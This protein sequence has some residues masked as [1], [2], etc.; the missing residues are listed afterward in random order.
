MRPQCMNLRVERGNWKPAGWTLKQN[1]GSLSQAA[2]LLWNIA[3]YIAYS[4]SSSDVYFLEQFDPNIASLWN[5]GQ[6]DSKWNVYTWFNDCADSADWTVP[7]V[8]VDESTNILNYSNLTDPFVRSKPDWVPDFLNKKTAFTRVNNGTISNIVDYLWPDQIQQYITADQVKVG[9]SGI[10]AFFK[11][12]VQLDPGQVQYILGNFG[13]KSL[14]SIMNTY[15]DYDV[16]S[17]N[18]TGAYISLAKI[19]DYPIQD[20]LTPV[21]AGLSLQQ[22]GQIMTGFVTYTNTALGQDDA[23]LG[24]GYSAES[25]GKWILADFDVA[26]PL[27]L[28][29]IHNV[30]EKPDSWIR[31]SDGKQFDH[32]SQNSGGKTVAPFAKFLSAT[33]IFGKTNASLVEWGEWAYKKGY[34][35]L[36]YPLE[37]TT[38]KPLSRA[39]QVRVAK[40]SDLNLPYNTYNVNLGLGST[41]TERDF[42]KQLTKATDWTCIKDV[43]YNDPGIKGQN[44][45]GLFG[46]ADYVTN[47]YPTELDTI[48]VRVNSQGVV[49]CMAQQNE[50]GELECIKGLCQYGTPCWKF[51]CRKCKKDP[52]LTMVSDE[53]VLTMSE[54][55]LPTELMGYGKCTPNIV[56]DSSA[57]IP[58]GLDPSWFSQAPLSSSQSLQCDPSNPTNWCK[59]ASE[60]LKPFV[61]RAKDGRGQGLFI[62]QKDLSWIQDADVANRHRFYRSNDHKPAGIIGKDVRYICIDSTTDLNGSTKVFGRECGDDDGRSCG[63][64]GFC[65]DI[66]GSGYGRISGTRDGNLFFDAQ[67]YQSKVKG[68]N[69][70]VDYS[71]E[72]LGNLARTPFGVGLT[73]TYDMQKSKLEDAI[74]VKEDEISKASKIVQASKDEAL[75][76]QQSKVISSAKSE[77]AALK[78]QLQNVLMNDNSTRWLLDDKGRFHNLSD[79]EQCMTLI[80]NVDRWSFSRVWNKDYTPNQQGVFGIFS[81]YIDPQS[82]FQTASTD[83]SGGGQISLEACSDD[84]QL[85]K[86]LREPVSSTPDGKV[87]QCDIE[88]GSLQKWSIGSFNNNQPNTLTN[89]ALVDYWQARKYADQIADENDLMKCDAI[90]DW[91]LKFFENPV[92]W[93]RKCP[94]KAADQLKKGLQYKLLTKNDYTISKIYLNGFGLG[95]DLPECG[96]G[97]DLPEALPKALPVKIEGGMSHLEFGIG[98]GGSRIKDRLVVIIHIDTGLIVSPRTVRVQ[99]QYKY[100]LVNGFALSKPDSFAPDGTKLTIAQAIFEV[101]GGEWFEFK[102]AASGKKIGISTELGNMVAVSSDLDD[103]SVRWK[104]GE[105]TIT[106]KLFDLMLTPQTRDGVAF[107]GAALFGT[108]QQTKFAFLVLGKVGSLKLDKSVIQ[109]ASDVDC[110]YTSQDSIEWDPSCQKSE[111]GLWFKDFPPVILTQP[112][113]K[114][115]A[116]PQSVMTQCETPRDCQVAPP[117]GQY[118]WDVATCKL[119]SDGNF[120][121]TVPPLILLPPTPGGQPCPETVKV[122][123]QPPKTCLFSAKS[124]QPWD[125]TC[126]KDPV[127]GEWSKQMPPDVFYRPSAMSIAAGADACPSTVTTKCMKPSGGQASVDFCLVSTNI[128]KYGYKDLDDCL[129]K[130]AIGGIPQDCKVVFPELGTSPICARDDNGILQT[131]I[132][133]TP[134][135]SAKNG[136]LCGPAQLLK[137][138]PCKEP[139]VSPEL[140]GKCFN[141]WYDQKFPTVQAC[142]DS[143]TGILPMPTLFTPMPEDCKIQWPEIPQNSVGCSRAPDGSDNFFVYQQGTVVEPAKEGGSCKTARLAACPA[144][145]VPDNVV[146]LCSSESERQ[147]LGFRSYTECVDKY[148]ID[149]Q[150]APQDCKVQWPEVPRDSVGCSRAADGSNNF[151]IFQRGAVIEPAK[152]GGQCAQTRV[153]EC[154]APV[155]SAEL[156][157]FCASEE[158]RQRNGFRTYTDCLDEYTIKGKPMPEDCKLQWPEVL[159]NSLGCVRDPVTNVLTLS[160]N[161]TI[162]EQAKNGGACKPT[163]TLTCSEPIISSEIVRLCSNA[164]ARTFYGFPNYMK[165]AD[166]FTIAG[167]ALPE[168]CKV[169]WPEIPANSV[170]CVRGADGGLSIVQNGTVVEPAKN[171]G[172]CNPTRVAVCPQPVIPDAVVRFCSSEENRIRNGF[173]SYGECADKYTIGGIPL[174]EDC[175][176]QWP[177]LPNNSVGCIRDPT[178]GILSIQQNATILEQAKNGGDCKPTRVAICSEPVVSAQIMTFCNNPENRTRNNYPSYSACVD[179][180]T[181]K[182]R[183]APK[184]CVVEWRTPPVNCTRD[185]I[186]LKLVGTQNATVLQPAENGGACTYTR[187]TTCAEPTVPADVD[188]YCGLNWSKLGY[189]S[190]LACTDDFVLNGKVL[191]KDCTVGF[192]STI[193]LK[194]CTRDSYTKRL[195][196]NQV[197]SII[198][199]AVGGGSCPSTMQ[200]RTIECPDPIALGT[201]P[202]NV[203]S[204][205]GKPEVVASFGNDTYRCIDEFTIYGR[206]VPQDCVLRWPDI[207]TS[208]QGC[209]RIAGFGAQGLRISQIASVVQPAVG[210]GYCPSIVR[211]ADC[212]EPVVSRELNQFCSSETRIFGKYNGSWQQC[213][214]AQL[215][216]PR[217]SP[218]AD[219]MSVLEGQVASTKEQFDAL[220]TFNFETLID[221]YDQSTDQWSTVVTP[222]A[223][224]TISAWVK[225]QTPATS[226]EVTGLIFG[227]YPTGNFGVAIYG[228]GQPRFFNNWAPDVYPSPVFK[229]T[230]NVWYHLVWTKNIANG[231]ITLF[232]NGVK[233][234]TW[235]GIINDA[236][237][238]YKNIRI[239]VDNHPGRAYFKGSLSTINVYSTVLSDTD[240]TRIY[241][242]QLPIVPK[243]EGFGYRVSAREG[244][245]GGKISNFSQKTMATAAVLL[246]VLFAARQILKLKN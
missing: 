192:P 181:I 94:L 74:R 102:H 208:Y 85:V 244:F 116:C 228:G 45:F 60:K 178:T 80:P 147:R 162:L 86:K 198:E 114:G 95:L 120:Y 4:T 199:P 217:E 155:V 2:D 230:P 226:T 215:G 117:Q 41:T 188:T 189:K 227:N 176:L 240:I 11:S 196:T 84:L 191:P 220:G 124:T 175:K 166:Y 154:P 112:R 3:N 219:I 48:A 169:Q 42:V 19:S 92:M 130:T 33:E 122:P 63:A 186:S 159:P 101:S 109:T 22:D 115:A 207:P 246:I 204:Y 24:V 44:F 238:N 182:G 72:N 218:Q 231:T 211:K 131:T 214:D 20:L 27:T 25:I 179:E 121:K 118:P 90:G 104:A 6:Y 177:G 141:A 28:N 127:T 5:S 194:T 64:G 183:P 59:T 164:E 93:T 31:C 38:N 241:N 132:V 133:G 23:T 123:C 54:D 46:N 128:S 173:R 221:Y 13:E 57:K 66:D 140:Y 206:Q 106:N 190:K 78:V 76:E 62:F 200:T 108:L 35:M 187:T 15:K 236:N 97:C 150:P 136:G 34:D 125:E 107:E 195:Y 55:N 36:N 129:E 52:A 225:I 212:P 29:S 224:G 99:D 142:L 103:D 18:P 88:D 156:I 197:A 39:A 51:G 139:D 152:N 113:G 100:K 65:E 10:T 70:V 168:D 134:Y 73:G 223:P 53:D 202:E 49:E 81:K 12:G 144:P 145:V 89:L 161:A 239:G 119:E 9:E 7:T 201:V 149:G 222:T 67:N 68:T 210:G 233:K 163:R 8:S 234:F 43:R 171:N 153:A 82:Q 96:A 21:K 165:C 237:V 158:N 135:E 91:N 47:N 180:Y 242:S 137:T 151:S 235:T 243:I 17:F 232:V 148:T 105:S 203:R 138:V 87:T 170:G 26:L 146:R 172:R 245:Y 75:I 1:V 77:L 30:T 209:S 157:G 16:F 184:D 71:F 126:T 205:C 174:P 37:R 160:Q 193:D 98:P 111:N 69:L 61:D 216:I 32:R 83:F 167:N 185:P 14:A 58:D 79:A 213:V 229:L 50:N 143:Y 56:L 110:V 40:L